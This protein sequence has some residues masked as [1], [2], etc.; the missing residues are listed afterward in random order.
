MSTQQELMR[1]YLTILE[2]NQQLDEG[3]LT[4]IIDQ[5][6]AK[7]NKISTDLKTTSYRIGH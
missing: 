4:P 6:R 2:E 1:K 3:L 7:F 5:V